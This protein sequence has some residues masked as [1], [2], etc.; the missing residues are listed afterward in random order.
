MNKLLTF[1]FQRVA[2]QGLKS[3]IF[4]TCNWINLALQIFSFPGHH[5]KKIRDVKLDWKTCVANTLNHLFPAK[6]EE[7]FWEVG[8]SCFGTA[9]VITIVFF[10]GPSTFLIRQRRNFKLCF[11][12]VLCKFVNKSSMWH[13]KPWSFHKN[14]HLY[15]NWFIVACS[16]RL[17]NDFLSKT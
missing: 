7:N 15:F 12:H 9:F 4:L 13:V 14:Q 1:T 2:G 6:L 5:K 3:K 10:S 11:K 8:F 16:N 17:I